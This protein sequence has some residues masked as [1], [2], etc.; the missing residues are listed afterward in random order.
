VI[1]DELRRGCDQN[2][3]GAA[4]PCWAVGTDSTVVRAHQH[5]AGARRSPPPH[6]ATEPTVEV[7]SNDKDGAAD[8]DR[9]ALGR[10][11][12]GLDTKINS[13]SR[14]L[15]PLRCARSFG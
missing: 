1:L 8:G 5:A 10:S 9:E 13:V 14:G 15:V 6:L 3:Q 12:G 2:A 11:P 7:A 4:D